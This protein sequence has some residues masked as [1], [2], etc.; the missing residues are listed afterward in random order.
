MKSV[1]RS[2]AFIANDAIAS[3]FRLSQGP[4][5]NEKNDPIER[6]ECQQSATRRQATG[7]TQYAQ[8]H[9]AGA[10]MLVLGWV[11]IARYACAVVRLAPY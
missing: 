3:R 9:G 1:L 4:C 5:F 10:A 6:P 2:V 7:D 11:R 8:V